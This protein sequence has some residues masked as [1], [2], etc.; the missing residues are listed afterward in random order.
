MRPLDPDL[1]RALVRQALEEELGLASM[2]TQKLDDSFRFR[3]RGRPDRT[4][5]AGLPTRIHPSHLEVVSE[6]GGESDFSPRKSCLIEP[7]RLCCNSGYC[8]KLGF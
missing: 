7:H 6:C 2:A 4:K 1:V 3:H 8:K 5:A